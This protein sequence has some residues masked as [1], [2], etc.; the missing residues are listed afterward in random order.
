[1]LNSYLVLITKPKTS[2]MKQLIPFIAGAIFLVS[3]NTKSTSEA[4]AAAPLNTDLIQQNLKGKVKTVTQ[5][6][7]TI[8]STGQE[9]TDSLTTVE[10]YDEKGY[11]T[12]SQ[13][14][15]SSGKITTEQTA[16]HDSAGRVLEFV[17][18]KDGK[19]TS[20][21][22]TEL[23]AAGNYIGGKTYDSTGKQDGYYKDLKQNE[24]GIVYSGKQYS[25]DGKIKADFNMKY[26]K[27]HFLGGKNTDST[28]KI[29]YEGT[30]KMNDKGDMS[31]ENLTYLEKGTTKTEKNTYKYDA[32]D[33]KG[34]WIKRTKY[35][36]K[37]RPVQFVTR[38][39]TYYN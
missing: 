37:G 8:D 11:S 14:K 7:T 31:E 9:R 19:M 12:M 20:K 28:G 23:D 15:N 17:T 33:E 36:D 21:L 22:E 30:A 35:N 3:C 6:S 27:T 24:Y 16:K 1:M 32:F 10:S 18:Y 29:T 2:N 38:T 25:M 4:G 34:N 39:L 5:T 13:T 26:D